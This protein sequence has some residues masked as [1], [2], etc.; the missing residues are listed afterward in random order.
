MAGLQTGLR[1]SRPARRWVLPAVVGA[2]SLGVWTV[3]SLRTDPEAD[4]RT[5][6]REDPPREDLPREGGEPPRAE[7]EEAAWDVSPEALRA[8]HAEVSRSLEAGRIDEAVAQFERATRGWVTL[9]PSEW[10]DLG[11]RLY[12]AVDAPG[13]ALWAMLHCPNT[14]GWDQRLNALRTHIREQR[15]GV[16]TG[17]ELGILLGELRLNKGARFGDV[18][19]PYGLRSVSFV[20]GPVLVGAN[21]APG[22]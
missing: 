7:V 19:Q 1:T 4:P 17:G 13:R 14:P 16:A 15:G 2:L 3:V 11:E 20:A 18:T 12:L 21:T 6:T 22:P 5:A 9:W 10:S 8:A